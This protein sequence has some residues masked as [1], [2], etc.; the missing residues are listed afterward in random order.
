[1]IAFLKEL[2][3]RERQS[4]INGNKV[5]LQEK[6]KKFVMQVNLTD[7]PKN[8]VVIK[9]PDNQIHLF[10]KQYKKICDYLIFSE[11]KEYIDV[12]FCELKIKSNKLN[13]KINHPCSQIQQTRPLLPY[14]CAGMEINFDNYKEKPKFKE[15]YVI[16]IEGRNSK[17]TTSPENKE[18]EIYEYNNLKIKKFSSYAKLSIQFQN[19]KIS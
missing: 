12:V 10:D 13:K 5:V 19:M 1:M 11:N 9:C 18:G 14:I 17:K 8:T 4:S 7:L 2:I 16:L 6:Q 15:H 3:D